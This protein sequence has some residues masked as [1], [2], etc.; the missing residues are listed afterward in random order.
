MAGNRDGFDKPTIDALAE[1]AGQHCS[2]PGC[3]NT[4]IGPSDE[5]S[6]SVS[7]NGMACHISGASAGASSRRYDATLTAEQRRSIENGIWMCYNHGK[8]IDTD[9]ARYSVDTLKKWRALTERKARLRQMFGETFKVLPSMLNDLGLPDDRI[10]LHSLGTE[11]ADIGQLIDVAMVAD[12][13]GSG[14]AHAIRDECIELARNAFQHGDAREFTLT[15][16]PESIQ[17]LD[18][19]ADHDL[20]RLNN[21]QG[22]SG[23]IIATKH[24]VDC[25]KERLL[26]VARRTNGRNETVFTY[27]NSADSILDLTPCSIEISWN[28]LKRRQ[29]PYKIDHSCRSICIVLPEYMSISDAVRLNDK[30]KIPIDDSRPIIFILTKTSPKAIEMLQQYFPDCLTVAT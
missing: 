23:G 7:R 16:T 10:T 11:N 1:R 18:D 8:L 15:I 27:V 17:I 9:F 14:I 5:S 26:I 24:L 25:L 21:M 12:L 28:E 29:L 3:A 13:W 19:G 20:W 30:L 6:T 22:Q 4:T 2:F